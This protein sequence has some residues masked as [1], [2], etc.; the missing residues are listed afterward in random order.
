MAAHG[1]EW[2]FCPVSEADGRVG[3]Q[4]EGL[5]LEEAVACSRAR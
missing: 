1:I 5:K 2:A 3:E 4:T